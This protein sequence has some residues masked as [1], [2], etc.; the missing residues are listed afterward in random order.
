MA[1]DTQDGQPFPVR[2]LSTEVSDRVTQ[3]ILDAFNR[4]GLTSE[5]ARQVLARVTQ[6]IDLGELLAT[7]HKDMLAVRVT[8]QA[9]LVPPCLDGQSRTRPATGLLQ[10]DFQ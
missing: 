2:S 7:Y 8:V 5:Q 10:L 9:C 3:Q 4:E 1:S 6:L